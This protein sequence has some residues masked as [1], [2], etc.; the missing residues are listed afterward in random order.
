MHPYAIRFYEIPGTIQIQPQTGPAG[1][2]DAGGTNP[3]ASSRQPDGRPLRRDGP[4]A[5]GCRIVRRLGLLHPLH[6]CDRAGAGHDPAGRRTVR[7]GRPQALC[8]AIAERHP[9]LH[10][11]RRGDVGLAILLRSATLPPQAAGRSSRHGRALLPDARLQHAADDALLR[12]QAI[13]RRRGQYQSRDGRD[14]HRQSGQYRIQLGLHLRP[15]RIPR[16][17][18]RGRRTGDAPRAGH[19]ADAHDRLLRRA[20]GIPCLP[21]RFLAAALFVDQRAATTPDGAAHFRCRCF[22]NRRPS[23][24]RAS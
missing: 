23:W 12:F 4:A 20:V 7:A 14:D 24:A 8:R 21:A 6:C 19:R 10:A 22:S 3:D 16:N 15:R 1:R 17:G 13:P 5:A 18:C 9:V 11:S 2:T